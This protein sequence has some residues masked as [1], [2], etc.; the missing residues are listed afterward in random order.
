MAAAL[1]MMG[2]VIGNLLWGMAA[3]RFRTNRKTLIAAL[4]ISVLM[5]M[6]LKDALKLWIPVRRF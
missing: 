5:Q 1:E 6:A 3:D 2:I 4:V